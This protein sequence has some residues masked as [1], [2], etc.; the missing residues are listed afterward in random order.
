MFSF[1][2]KKAP[3][4]ATPTAPDL[5]DFASALPPVLPA[6][7]APQFTLSPSIALP[8][9][10]PVPPAATAPPRPAPVSATPA[11]SAP[12]PEEVAPARRPWL[13]RL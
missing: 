12:P 4:P 10:Q 13:D 6:A 9:P 1:F 8:P 5:R 7:P 2:K 3:S 11:F